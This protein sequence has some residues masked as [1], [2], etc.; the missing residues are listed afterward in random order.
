M[1]EVAIV[2]AIGLLAAIAWGRLGRLRRGS[3]ESW[4]PLALRHAELAFSEQTFRSHRYGLVARLDR[5][6]RQDGTLTLVEYKTRRFFVVYR[7][8]VIELS[9]QRIALSEVIG[10]PVSIDAYVL[11]QHATTGKRRV[12]PTQLLGLDEVLALKRRRQVIMERRAVRLMPA[13]STGLCVGCAHLCRCQ[14][15]FGDREV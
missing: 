15:E 9:V 13:R 4:R 11:V 5:A 14:D 3:G 2:V 7:S 1:T 12:L 10:E 6:Y 8:D